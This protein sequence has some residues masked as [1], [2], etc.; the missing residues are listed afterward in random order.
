MEV[1]KTSEEESQEISLNEED[2][3]IHVFSLATGALYERLLRIM[4]TSVVKRSSSKVK[5][6]LLE[7]Y[8]TSEM[9][10]GL[11]KLSKSLHFEY[12]LVSFEWPEWLRGQTEKQRKI[13]GY[14]ILF[15]DVLF[16]QSVKKIIYVDADQVVRA[17][18]CDF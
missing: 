15:L 1:I 2:D 13:W 4:M 9:K 16:P 3:T 6:W 12:E 8:M 11:E 5:F 7:N 14:K 10:I 17:G 18:M